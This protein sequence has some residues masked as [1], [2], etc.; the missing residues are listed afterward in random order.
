MASS[1][2]ADSKQ[3]HKFIYSL[4][5]GAT[6][7]CSFWWGTAAWTTTTMAA[8]TTSDKFILVMNS[9]SSTCWASTSAGI[10]AETATT[11]GLILYASPAGNYSLQITDHPNSK[12]A[13]GTNASNS[14]DDIYLG[15]KYGGTEAVGAYAGNDGNILK[16]YLYDGTTKLG[17]SVLV[18]GS[19]TFTFSSGA[20]VV[21]PANG[22]KTLTLKADLSDYNSAIEGSTLSF[23]IGSAASNYYTNYMEAVGASSGA[24]STIYNSAGAT[25]GDLAAN[26]MY[27]Y[28]TKPTVSLN[29]ASPSGAQSVGTNK[30]VFRF[31]VANAN[32]GNDLNI[33]AIRFTIS[34]NASSAAMDKLYKLYKSS[35]L[36]TV[37]GQA[38][39]WASATSSATTGYVTI[40]P[41]SG[42]TVGSGSTVTYVLKANTSSMNESSSKTETLTLSIEDTDF[43]FNDSLAASAN[44]K[45]LNLPVTGNTLSY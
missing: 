32:T 23:S 36:S 8:A 33:Q 13:V 37:I 10:M 6:S 29:S 44:Q 40:Y 41:Y 18:N 3:E 14:A 42:Y 4:N 21:I 16:T 35:D 27:L 5:G 17:E 9:A 26:T 2:V 20:E 15:V 31:D 45:V 25:S 34:T 28:G 24:T 7:T 30:E 43:F 19:S 39:S 38:V 12:D 11:S 22:S 1:T